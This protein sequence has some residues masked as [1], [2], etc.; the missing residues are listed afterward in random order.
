MIRDIS[1][2]A[3]RQLRDYDDRTPGTI[4]AEGL[5]FNEEQAY[6]V[7]SEVCRL[8]EQRGETVAGYKI[9]C[10]SPIIQQ[11]LGHSSLATTDRYVRHIAPVDLISHM[12]RREW[13][14][15]ND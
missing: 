9:G 8:R 1:Q 2:L 10:T 6:A 13:S 5:S 12:Q 11:Q 4:F 3:A 7:Q 14:A 15:E